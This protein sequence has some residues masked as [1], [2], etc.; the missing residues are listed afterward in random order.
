MVAL[1]DPDDK[2]VVQKEFNFHVYA[3]L[4]EKGFWETSDV[5]GLSI[6]SEYSALHLD[7]R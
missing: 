2:S 7:Y 3:Y 1:Y 6:Q 4:I 5:K